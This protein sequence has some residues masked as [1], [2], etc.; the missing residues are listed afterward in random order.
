MGRS[1]S[2]APAV[3]SVLPQILTVVLVGRFADALQ[4]GLS[5]AGAGTWGGWWVAGEFVEMPLEEER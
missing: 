3:I 1:G 5:S 4:L 2:G